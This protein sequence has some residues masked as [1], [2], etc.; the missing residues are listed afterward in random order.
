MDHPNV[1]HQREA[2]DWARAVLDQPDRYVILD[3]ETTGLANDDEVIQLGV[4]TP[5]GEVLLDHFIRPTQKR[6]IHPKAQQVHGIA[7]EMLRDKPL[8]TQVA[9]LLQGVVQGKTIV[10]YNAEFDR[11]LLSQTAGFAGGFMPPDPW[12]CAM[13]QYA[14][15]VGEWDDFRNKY[16]WHKLHGGDHTAVGDCKA[17]L[18]RIREMATSPRRRYSYEMTVQA[19]EV[20]AGNEAPPPLQREPRP[21]RRSMMP[22]FGISISLDGGIQYFGQKYEPPTPEEQD[23]ELSKGYREKL[24]AYEQANSC[25]LASSV[26][27]VKFL[28]ASF[29]SMTEDEIKEAGRHLT[30]PRVAGYNGRPAVRC[31]TLI[32]KMETATAKRLYGYA[33]SLKDAIHLFSG[34]GS[35][36]DAVRT[37]AITLKQTVEECGRNELFFRSQ[38]IWSNEWDK[39]RERILGIEKKSE[40]KRAMNEFIKKIKDLCDARSFRGLKEERERFID[41]VKAQ[42]E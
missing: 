16:R 6:Y 15:F 12:A 33:D 30:Q 21:E 42:C 13:L 26:D 1:R 41:Y 27:V 24:R 14:Q 39:V 23:A 32:K 11:R 17:T 9:H 36:D 38:I 40:R 22:A 2:I 18:A 20:V 31:F 37:E 10:T 19:D 34:E 29:R 4:I 25:T 35:K 28:A 8:Y 5:S 7:M 3:T